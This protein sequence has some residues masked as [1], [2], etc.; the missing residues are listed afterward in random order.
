R[1]EAL[2]LPLTLGLLRA[3][4]QDASP[5]WV[6]LEPRACLLDRDARPL[7]G[8]LPGLEPLARALPEGLDDL[9]LLA[10][11]FYGARTWSHFHDAHPLSATPGRYVTWSLDPMDGGERIEGIK[12][13]QQ[14]VL[15]WRDRQ[16][17]GLP[18]ELLS[19]GQLTVERYFHGGRLIAWRLLEPSA[20]AS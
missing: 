1:A 11:S 6:S 19:T 9:P 8:R 12:A 18:D 17:F 2:D 14:K 3:R 10:A 4:W 5:L 16:R 13:K 7:T 20:E 15:T